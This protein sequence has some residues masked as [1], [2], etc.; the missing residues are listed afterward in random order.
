MKKCTRF[1][2]FALQNVGIAG[3]K[4]CKKAK[5]EAK[6]YVKKRRS[7]NVTRF[8]PSNVHR[9]SALFLLRLVTA[10]VVGYESPG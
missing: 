5:G 2:R 7:G 8:S 10:G 3:I 1:E 4:E 6:K 9:V